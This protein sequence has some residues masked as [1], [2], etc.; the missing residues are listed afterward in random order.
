[1][2]FFWVGIVILLVLSKW[3]NGFGEYSFNE[4]ELSWLD[5]YGES[6]AAPTGLMVG[7]TLIPG[8]GAKGAGTLTPIISQLSVCFSLLIL[9]PNFG[10]LLDLDR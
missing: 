4:T 1:M 7:L 8:A 9:D 6:K 2:K 5:G 3:A 10:A